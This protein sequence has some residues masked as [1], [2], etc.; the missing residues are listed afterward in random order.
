M[1]LERLAAVKQGVYSNYDTDLF[2]LIILAAAREADA[3]GQKVGQC[4][5]DDHAGG[6]GHHG[7]QAMRETEYGKPAEQGRGEGQDA[8]QPDHGLVAFWQAGHRPYSSSR[9][10]SIW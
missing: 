1:G 7:V 9:W 3:L 10:A 6:E 8:D 4:R 5:R 2:Q